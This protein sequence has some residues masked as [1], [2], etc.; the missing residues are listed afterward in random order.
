MR[1]ITCLRGINSAFLV[2]LNSKNIKVGCDAPVPR[3]V[4]GKGG[5]SPRRKAPGSIRYGVP[6]RRR[7]RNARLEPNP[8]VSPASFFRARSRAIGH[9][10]SLPT[11]FCRLPSSFSSLSLAS[12]YGRPFLATL[13]LPSRFRYFQSG[14]H[15][16][17]H[18]IFCI[19]S[20]RAPFASCRSSLRSR[21]S[22]SRQR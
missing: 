19:V 18:C 9:P 5:S 4:S 11:L 17:R 13:D 12:S 6:R 8:G 14:C 15:C 3:N 20:P 22:V 2:T 1:E 16:T 7:A 10:V 21:S